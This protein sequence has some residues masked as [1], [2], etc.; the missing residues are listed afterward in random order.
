MVVV[1]P[2]ELGSGGSS[3]D[4]GGGNRSATTAGIC[5]TA[6]GV[7]ATSVEQPA[8]AANNVANSEAKGPANGEAQG[9]ANGA[10]TIRVRCGAMTC[11]R[12]SRK[13]ELKRLTLLPI[14]CRSQNVV[15]M[16]QL[17]RKRAATDL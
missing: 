16:N 1:G 8:T 11:D 13:R 10:A 9:E 17:Q 4:L 2:E 12:D 6:S 3:T 15:L 5:A 7:V 14:R